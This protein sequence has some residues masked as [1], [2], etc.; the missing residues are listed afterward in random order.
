MLFNQLVFGPVKSRR[1][2]V[3]LGINLLPTESKLC[4]FECIYC[5]CGWSEEKHTKAEFADREQLILALRERL[6]QMKSEGTVPDAITFAGNGEPTM[7]PEFAEIIDDVIHVRDQFAT[8]AKIVVLTNAL[9]ADRV[10][11]RRGLMQADRRILKLDAADP[12]MFGLINGPN[13]VNAFQKIADTLES[14]AGHIEVQTMFLT[15]ESAGRSIDNTSEASVAL[16]INELK[17]IKPLSVQLYSVDREAPLHSVKPV[18]KEKL[19]QLA[20]QV[21]REGIPA[22]VF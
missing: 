1:F 6:I 9:L 20:E 21:R 12:E 13:N 5:E 14:Y 2:G 15:A 7:H 16:W 18:S 4:N 19:R 17:K 3:S 10:N 8:G 22:A 11:V